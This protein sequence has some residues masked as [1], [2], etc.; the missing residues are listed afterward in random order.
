M[1]DIRLISETLAT[2]C[3][4]IPD[5]RFEKKS[6]WKLEKFA[7]E[8]MNQN[9]F[10]SSTNVTNLIMSFDEA[11]NMVSGGSSLKACSWKFVLVIQRS[12]RSI[13]NLCDISTRF[14]QEK[15]IIKSL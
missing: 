8:K 9:Y 2:I 10:R 7:V 13:T 5:H 14:I 1:R 12:W 6:G 4:H 15:D 11:K 3:T